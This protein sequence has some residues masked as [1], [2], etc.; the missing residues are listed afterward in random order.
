MHKFSYFDEQN[1]YIS[2]RI[3][4]FKPSIASVHPYEIRMQCKYIIARANEHLIKTKKKIEQRKNINQKL[5]L[6]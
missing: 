4:I 6:C 2:S 5:I 3:Y 1:Y